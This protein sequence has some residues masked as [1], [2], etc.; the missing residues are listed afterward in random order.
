MK[1]GYCPIDRVDMS[2]YQKGEISMHKCLNTFQ[3][4]LFSE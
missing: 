4:V 3:N 1:T 2:Y